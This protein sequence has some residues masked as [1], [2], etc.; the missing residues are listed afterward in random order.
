M[1][2]MSSSGLFAQSFVQAHIIER[3]GHRWIPPQRASNAEKV[4]MWWRR[5]VQVQHQM[6]L[7]PY[8]CIHSVTIVLNWFSVRSC[9]WIT[10]SCGNI[11]YC[12]IS[13][14][15]SGHVTWLHLGYLQTMVFTKLWLISDSHKTLTLFDRNSK[16]LTLFDRNSS[17]WGEIII[18]HLTMHIHVCWALL[19]NSY[20]LGLTNYH[21]ATKRLSSG[22][23]WTRM[24]I[25][26]A[27]TCCLIIRIIVQ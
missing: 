4:S 24:Q 10:L 26:V 17:K 25:G 12:D 2:A 1:S 16:T 6:G 15:D 13:I 19:E 11:W 5:H 20:T 27:K 22:Q 18:N 9:R 8:I 3:N 7:S 14:N 23:D 21:Y